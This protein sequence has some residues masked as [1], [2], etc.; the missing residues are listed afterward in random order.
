MYQGRG[1]YEEAKVEWAAT[2]DQQ[3]VKNTYFP[4]REIS[5]ASRSFTTGLF[6]LWI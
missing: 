6:H 5:S 1:E 4:F 3:E 2:Y